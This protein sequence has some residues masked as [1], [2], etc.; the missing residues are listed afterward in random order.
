[1]VADIDGKASGDKSGLSVGLSS[2]GNTVAVGAPD[3][4]GDRSG[5]ARVF[6]CIESTAAWTQM[7][8]DIDG[9]AS[10]D[11]SDYSVSLSLDDIT[12]AIG[13]PS[14]GVKSGH[15]GIFKWNHE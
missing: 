15:V 7:I 1:M 13:A 11:I 10:G 4:N 5:H 12:V 6:Q 14:N 3:E 9:E 2:D 8:A